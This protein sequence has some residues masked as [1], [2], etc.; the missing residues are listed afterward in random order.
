M[1][2][3]ARRYFRGLVMFFMFQSIVQKCLGSP[4][5]RSVPRLG[6]P[7]CEAALR[8]SGRAAQGHSAVP[9]RRSVQFPLEDEQCCAESGVSFVQVLRLNRHFG[10]GERL[11]LLY[12]HRM[13][14]HKHDMI[15]N[16]YLFCI[17]V[18]II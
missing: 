14:I 10:S 18:C 4:V 13:H 7:S 11:L 8:G 17:I 6:V 5:G 1:D 15:I 9:C 2:I 12:M 16:M 3:S